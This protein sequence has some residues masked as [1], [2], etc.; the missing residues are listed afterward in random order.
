VSTD[1]NLRTVERLVGVAL[2]FM[3]FIN[4]LLSISGNYPLDQFTVITFLFGVILFVHGSGQ[5]WHK[6]IIIGLAAALVAVFLTRDEVGGLTQLA[7]FWGTVFVI[8]FYTFFAK[9]PKSN[10][11]TSRKGTGTGD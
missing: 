3:G 2:I 4:I 7:L 1:Q 8:L 10:E 11:D 6:W 9:E 5:T